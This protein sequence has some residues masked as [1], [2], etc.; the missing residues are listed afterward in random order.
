VVV[1]TLKEVLQHQNHTVKPDVYS[2]PYSGSGYGVNALD[3][4]GFEGKV[5]VYTFN[6]V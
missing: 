2:T 4:M 3:L 6:T 1:A 5:R